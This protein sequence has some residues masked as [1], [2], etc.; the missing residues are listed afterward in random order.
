MTQHPQARHA[1]RPCCGT[2]GKENMKK[3]IVR[4][5][6]WPI[7]LKLVFFWVVLEAIVGTFQFLYW[8]KVTNQFWPHITLLGT[9]AFVAYAAVLLSLI[10]AMLFRRRTFVGIN[11]TVAAVHM[12]VT[13]HW[14]LEVACDLLEMFQR[15]ADL[16]GCWIEQYTIWM[17][18]NAFIFLAWALVFW[19]LM[20]YEVS[21]RK[22]EVKEPNQASH[23]TSEPAPGPSEGAR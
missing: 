9:Y 11:L 4:C 3:R 22:D 21:I 2:V 19:Y 5:M 17:G 12:F 8:A 23:T 10:F 6:S 14:N 18:W 7:G 20:R 16:S 1:S 13:L 15:R